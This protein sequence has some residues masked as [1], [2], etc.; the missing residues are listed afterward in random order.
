MRDLDYIKLVKAF[1]DRGKASNQIYQLIKCCE[2]EEVTDEQFEDLKTDII[3]LMDSMIGELA[4]E[5][6]NEILSNP[7]PKDR[8]IGDYRLSFSLIPKEE[9]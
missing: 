2:D 9:L 7:L 3:I 5:I 8:D 1:N 4:Q 6:T